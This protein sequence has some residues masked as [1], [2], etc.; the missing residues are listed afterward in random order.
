[1]PLRPSALQAS[2]HHFED[3]KNSA[4]EL[5]HALQT[6]S[7]PACLQCTCIVESLQAK[8]HRLFS[9]WSAPTLGVHGRKWGEE[10]LLWRYNMVQ[11]QQ[12]RCCQWADSRI[13]KA[14]HMLNQACSKPLARNLRTYL[15]DAK[16]PS[17][18]LATRHIPSLTSAAKQG[19]GQGRMLTT[20]QRGGGLE[21]ITACQEVFQ[22]I[23]YE[24]T[25]ACLHL[26]C[27]VQLGQHITPSEEV[28]TAQRCN[29]IRNE[30]CLCFA[31]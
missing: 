12:T 21:G 8:K 5:Q 6:R 7:R 3:L 23:V 4:A 15:R 25:C 16:G 31:D 29:A 2:R 14:T 27:C 9:S 1:M 22:H 26:L 19:N 28:D 11:R 18:V 17:G 13:Y 10:V 24:Q 20:P 30:L